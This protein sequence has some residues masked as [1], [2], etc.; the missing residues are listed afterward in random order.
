[1]DDVSE[2]VEVPEDLEPVTGPVDEDHGPTFEIEKGVV[3][4]QLAEEIQAA[5]EGKRLNISA[6]AAPG[7]KDAFISADDEVLTLTVSS[8]E[9]DDEEISNT[10]QAL[11][12]SHQPDYDYGK[13]EP[14]LDSIKDRLSSG[15][16]LNLNEVTVALR[17]LFR[18]A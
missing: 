8:P 4:P 16:T 10:V 5:F 6:D 17:E 9:V 15:E 13:G 3:F 7:A 14:G 12:D 11:I 2:Q 1:M 18:L